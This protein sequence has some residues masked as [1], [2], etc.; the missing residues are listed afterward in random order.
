MIK[1]SITKESAII[2]I[3]TLYDT[4]DDLIVELIKSYSIDMESDK[5]DNLMRMRGRIDILKKQKI[6]IE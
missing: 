4:I 1:R 6:E 2:E 5:R 3:E